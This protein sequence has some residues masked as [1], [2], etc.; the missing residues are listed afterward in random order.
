MFI[1]MM[2][3]LIIFFSVKRV[4][5]VWFKVC[6][7]LYEIFKRGRVPLFYLLICDT[8]HEKK[9]KDHTEPF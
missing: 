2:F 5:G 4:S 6:S 3:N 1:V 9:R 8:N 7:K